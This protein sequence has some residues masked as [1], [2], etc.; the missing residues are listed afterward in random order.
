M[1]APSEQRQ[2]EILLKIQ[3]LLE[4]GKFSSTYK[5]ALLQA[6]IE[7]AVEMGRDDDQELVVPTRAIAEKFIASYWPQV[8]PFV[9]DTP[10]A[11]QSEP[12]AAVAEEMTLYP[13]LVLR[14]GTQ[15]GAAIPRAVQA[16]AE[17][18]DGSLSR[19][20]FNA[21]R[22]NIV[23]ATV[24]A[25]VCS[26]PLWH[27]QNIGT[28]T[29]DFLY[30][31]PASQTGVDSVT[32]RP[33]TAFTL[34]RFQHLLR[35]MVRGAWAGFIRGLEPNRPILGD[36][37]DLHEF[38][39]GQPRR[40]LEACRE[41]LLAWQQ[42]SCLYCGGR[43]KSNSLHVDHFIPWSRFPS[44]LAHNLVA[45]CAPC[46]NS[47]RS[48]LA[49]LPHLEAWHMRNSTDVPLIAL[50]DRVLFADH[51]KTKSIACWAYTQAAAANA[52]VWSQKNELIP[53]DG[54]WREILSAPA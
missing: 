19:A 47:K 1:S 41:P 20:R 29:D 25:T 10:T 3:R 26:M 49:A 48:H 16:L 46:N 6:L 54:R 32:L 31:R 2:V 5:F 21:P 15:D 7:C 14:Q 53:L 34:R 38:L 18:F 50:A 9:R 4:E 13:S 22:W 33:G 39:F 43:I 23:V 8:R 42:G 45:S 30:E 11:T 37:E 40:S 35:E 12:V 44:S 24:R 51:V 17:E 28:A 52:N 27:L 36:G